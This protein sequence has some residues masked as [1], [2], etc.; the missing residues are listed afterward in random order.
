[1]VDGMEIIKARLTKRA[2]FMRHANVNEGNYL[3]LLSRAV[4]GEL[5]Y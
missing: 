4:E 5:L 1:M 2:F 3:A